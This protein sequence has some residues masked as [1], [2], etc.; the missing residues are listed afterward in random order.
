MSEQQIPL[1]PLQS[2]TFPGASLTLH[3][4]EPRYREMIGRCLEANEPFGVVLIRQG[5]E[6]GD[7][8]E[9]YPVGTLVQINASVK[10]ED[11]RLL[12][13][14][15][16]QKRFR[17]AEMVQ[18]LPYL[19]GTV[20]LL[21]DESD[22]DTATLD[23]T[24]RTTYTEYWQAIVSHTGTAVE[25]EEL[26]DDTLTMSYV[27]AS[28][29]QVSNERKQHWLET[30]LRRRLREMIEAM[31]AELAMLPRGASLPPSDGF[32]TPWSWN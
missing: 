10:L 32:T 30:S 4:F 23:A 15:I 13:A 26:P 20:T 3:I 14:T 12:I 6:V 22:T 31:R 19:V 21:D 9:P 17:I 29:L 27:L 8:A 2:V 1:F 11:G 28:R 25:V 5:S 7:P 18:I 24:L 16:G